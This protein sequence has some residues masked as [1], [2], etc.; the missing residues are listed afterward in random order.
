MGGGLFTQI[1]GLI[2]PS[3][4]WRSLGAHS[5]RAG[6]TH[7]GHRTSLH[8]FNSTKAEAGGAVWC[9]SG[10]GKVKKQLLRPGLT[11]IIQSNE[12]DV[13]LLWS[14]FTL[15]WSLSLS[16]THTQVKRQTER[17]HSF[18]ENTT[19]LSESPAPPKW[20]DGRN[21]LD[22]HHQPRA[23]SSNYIITGQTFTES[24]TE[25]HRLWDTEWDG[26]MWSDET[27]LISQHP[28]LLTMNLSKS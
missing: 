10:W 5:V 1:H 8:Q 20:R 18:N 19:L 15:L 11:I 7:S 28:E 6:A 4:S 16:H 27:N 14:L 25:P 26:N 13:D 9:L 23:T 21:V 12:E 2:R 22:Q 17:L 24:A 3:G